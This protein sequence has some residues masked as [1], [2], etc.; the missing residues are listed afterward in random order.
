[1]RGRTSWRHL[2]SETGGCQN[3]QFFISLDLGIQNDFKIF[4]IFKN[5][6]LNS[7]F[8]KIDAF[9]WAGAF[10][11]CCDEFSMSLMMCLS[12]IWPNSRQKSLQNDIFSSKM[13]VFVRFCIK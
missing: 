13:T 12:V 1:M 7:T 11:A 10:R 5:I 9:G 3:H 6:G 2:V 4:K 8:F